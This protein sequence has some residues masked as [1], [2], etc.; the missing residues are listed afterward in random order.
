MACN[1]ARSLG[2]QE[3]KSAPPLVTLTDPGGPN[4]GSRDGGALTRDGYLHNALA[5]RCVRI[6][7]E[8]AASVPLTTAHEAAAQLIR[9]PAP[10]LP[11]AAF[12]EGVY[13]QLQLFGM[14]SRGRCDFREKWR[15]SRRSTPCSRTAC[16]R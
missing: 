11:G 5:Y 9:K 12:L 13:T 1:W 15:A 7:A 3:A 10:D 4:W 2:R 16:V 8:A 6:V 14:H